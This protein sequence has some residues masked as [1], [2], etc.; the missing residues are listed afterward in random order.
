MRILR[1]IKSLTVSGPTTVTIGMFDGVHRGHKKILKL[2]RERAGT[3][4]RKG[5]VLTFEPHPLRVLRSR[6]T[7][8]MLIS[9]K[10]RLNLLKEEGVDIVAVID[11]TRGFART[12]AG[13]FVENILVKKLHAKELLVG[14]NFVFGKDKSCDVDSLKKLGRK[15]GFSVRVIQPLSTDGK[16]ISSTLIRKLIMS[17]KLNQAKRLL[18]RDASILGTVVKGATRGRV[19]GFP[20]A[21]LDPHHEAIPPS[22]VYIVKVRIK[23]KEFPG[24][25]NIGFRPTFNKL[26]GHEP[27]V[28][29][30]IFGFSKSLYGQDI[31]VIFLKKIRGERRFKDHEKLL[32]R[33]KKDVDMT[34]RYF[35]E[36]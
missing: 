11:F 24:V 26:K 1:G 9:V 14:A 6:K 12:E 4:K 23:K 13:R 19:L 35:Q 30:H 25:L 15:F 28:E 5:C 3:I 2:L 34:R 8:P 22:G 32:S 27:V 18:G 36:R 20:T 29:V 10:H 33:I 7:P 17:G 21:N 16:V 31:E